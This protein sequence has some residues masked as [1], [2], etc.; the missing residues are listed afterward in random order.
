MSL[1]FGIN[2]RCDFNEERQI[3]LRNAT[4]A[5]LLAKSHAKERGGLWK[6]C[7]F[8]LYKS[9]HTYNKVYAIKVAM[10]W[11]YWNKLCEKYFG[12]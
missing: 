1:V 2:S 5:I 9:H 11:R 7:Q 8:I 10:N 4:F 12:A 6:F 3:Q